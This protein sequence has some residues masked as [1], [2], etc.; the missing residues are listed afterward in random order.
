MSTTGE[1][2]LSIYSPQRTLVQ[3][4]SVKSIVLTGTEGE[5]EIL[6]EHAPLIGQLATGTFSYLDPQGSVVKGFIST[7]F[8]EVTENHVKVT[9]DTLE[10][11]HEIDLDRAQKAQKEAEK[12]LISDALTFESFDKYQL[13]LQRALVR[14]Q[15]AR[16]RDS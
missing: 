5:V 1:L 9:A 3:N 12:T 8:Y 6:P 14:Q 16:K 4:V 15:I 11:S 13:K 10:L 7:G 2:K